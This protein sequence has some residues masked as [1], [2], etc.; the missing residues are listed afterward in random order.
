[1]YAPEIAMPKI[2]LLD[3]AYNNSADV[4][5]YLNWTGM[6]YI[7]RIAAPSSRASNRVMISSTEQG[8]R[9]E[10]KKEQ[11]AFRL[12]AVKGRD[13]GDRV[14]LLFVMSTTTG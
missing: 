1:M 13:R 6:K 10:G 9:G 12:V 5:N 11:A 7:I 3:G 2:V 8:A 14:R 4:I